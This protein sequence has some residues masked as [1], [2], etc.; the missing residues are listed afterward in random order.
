MTAERTLIGVH[1]IDEDGTLTL[2]AAAFERS[3]LERGGRA[4]VVASPA[5]G[6]TVRPITEVFNPSPSGQ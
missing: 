1:E 4:L 3:G 5:G 6:V 2:D